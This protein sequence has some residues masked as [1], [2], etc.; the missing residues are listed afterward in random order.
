MEA[1][2]EAEQNLEMAFRLLIETHEWGGKVLKVVQG[3]TQL[4]VAQVG[5]ALE[6]RLA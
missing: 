2:E 3:V 1:E 6:V 5:V 4:G